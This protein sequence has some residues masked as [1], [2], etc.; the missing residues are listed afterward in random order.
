MVVVYGSYFITIYI[1][2]NKTK[3]RKEKRKRKKKKKEN[4]NVKSRTNYLTM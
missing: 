3:K 1:R 2:T 4:N